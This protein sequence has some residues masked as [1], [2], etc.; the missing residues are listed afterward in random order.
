MSGKYILDDNDNAVECDDLLKWAAWIEDAD[1]HVG[2]TQISED[3]K[4]STV[5]LGLDHSFDDG[6]PLLFETMVFGGEHDELTR[7]YSTKEQAVRG[8]NEV[9]EICGGKNE[10]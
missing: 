5:F 3:V 1:I 10:V 8:H 9:V 7:R 6:P 4:V 2:K